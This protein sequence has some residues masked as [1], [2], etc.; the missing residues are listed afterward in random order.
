MFSS[1]GLLT[2]KKANLVGCQV[3]MAKRIGPARQTII[4]KSSA[5]NQIV[6]N[7]PFCAKKYLFV[8]HVRTL[9]RLCLSKVKRLTILQTTLIQ[10]P[11]LLCSVNRGS[12]TSCD[13]TPVLNICLYIKTRTNHKLHF[14]HFHKSSLE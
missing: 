12:H 14:S 4:P 11:W 6:A 2:A 13:L 9:L 5:T 10:K 1:T 7:I 3:S 8:F